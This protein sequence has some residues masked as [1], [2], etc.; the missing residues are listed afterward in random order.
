MSFFKKMKERLFKASSK[1]TGGVEAIADRK[2]LDDTALE[3]L[4]DLLI[5][6]DLGVNVAMRASRH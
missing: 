4:E 2:V 3:E 1:I 5:Q 6:A